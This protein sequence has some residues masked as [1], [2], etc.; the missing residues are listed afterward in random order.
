[1]SCSAVVSAQM[2]VPTGRDTLRAL[3]GVEIIVEGTSPE[4][5][6]LG[7]TSSGLRADLDRRLRAGGVTIYG[8]QKE[9]PSTAKPYLYLILDPLELPGGRFAVAIQLH[10]RQ[11]LQSKVTGSNVVNAMTWDAHTVL[12]FAPAEVPEVKAAIIEMVDVFV[13]DWR[14]VH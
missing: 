9:N 7:L 11:T 4:L 13:S 2:F 1:M 6:R 14:A 5:E 3:P 8:G 12:A 10:L